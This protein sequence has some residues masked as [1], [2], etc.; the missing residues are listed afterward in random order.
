MSHVEGE[1]SRGI[2]Y[3]VWT[4]LAT[5]I[6]RYSDTKRM[7]H[8]TDLLVHAARVKLLSSAITSHLKNVPGH[9]FI[10]DQERV[11]YLARHHDDPELMTGD[12]PYSIKQRFTDEQKRIL[13]E[14]EDKAILKLSR[15]FG[16]RGPNGKAYIKGQQE[17]RQKKTLE[18]QIVKTADTI[19]AL[20]EITNE[21]RCGNTDFLPKLDVSRTQVVEV[22]AK[23][24]FFPLMASRFGLKPEDMP[25]SEQ[26]KDLPRISISDV[27]LDIN[28]MVSFESTYQWPLY[29]RIWLNI[30]GV[31][32]PNS[33]QA[34]IFPGWTDKFSEKQITD[35]PK[36]W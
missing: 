32:I 15:A 33:P 17:I 28:N 27:P 6:L 23:Y 12:F 16:L 26:M 3:H 34:V 1:L 4:P 19:D 10:P 8:P 29:Y 5:D 22:V 35:K 2:H 30:S 7:V 25:S 11:S 21:I 9:N 24:G 31:L 18:S 20:G 13:E 36:Q 14:A